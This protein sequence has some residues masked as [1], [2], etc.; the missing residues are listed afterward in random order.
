MIPKEPKPLME[1]DQ[2][3]VY[4]VDARTKIQLAP[5]FSPFFVKSSPPD[6]DETMRRTQQS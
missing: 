6:A 5:I 2:K 1:I 4:E 3:P